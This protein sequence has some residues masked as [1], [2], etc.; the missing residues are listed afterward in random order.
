M[1]VSGHIDRL[2][3]P[4]QDLIRDERYSSYLL[5]LTTIIALVIANSPARIDYEAFL[6]LSI[7][8]HFGE[9]TFEKSIKHWVNDGLMAM[10]FYT[11]G[12]EVKRE[13]LVGELK[14][15]RNSTAIIFSAVGGMIVPAAT[16]FLLN[17]NLSTVDGWGIPM[18]TDAAF[19]VGVLSL[20]KGRIP[21]ALTAFLVALAII[22]DLGAIA[23]IALFYTKTINIE[24]LTGAC[25]LF[26]LLVLINYTGV[27]RS[28]VYFLAGIVLWFLM[29]FSGVHPTLAGVA[30]ALTVPARPEHSDNWMIR[31]IEW[32]LKLIKI[33][34]VQQQH[35]IDMLADEK[36]HKLVERLEESARK[37]TTPLRRWESSLE[38]PVILFVLPIFALV[39][40]GIPVDYS[41]LSTVI[42]DNLSWGIILGLFIGKPLGI[43]LFCWLSTKTGYG[44]LPEGLSFNQI[45]GMAM[46]GGIG[47][48]MSIF[49]AG[50]SFSSE[51]L[52]GSAKLSVFIASLMSGILGFIWLRFIVTSK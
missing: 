6:H 28:S 50:L 7:G 44:R 45:A 13:F 1:N 35:Q 36:Q 15:I 39:N 27:R 31:R 30:V 41:I 46:L 4:F 25:I 19:A 51:V 14:D 38:R 33:R 18:A 24:A 22:D 42:K 12:L 3:S 17:R 43:T 8:F 20:L 37:V 32:L 23:V 52:L 2:V 29:E 11:L 21:V 48:T 5:I 47:F 34:K 40:A 10:F 16:F 49:I 26:G 9:W